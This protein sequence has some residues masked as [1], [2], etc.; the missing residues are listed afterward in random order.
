VT[1]TAKV[2]TQFAAGDFSQ[3][4]RLAT[5]PVASTLRGPT[6]TEEAAALSPWDLAGHPLRVNNELSGDAAGRLN[7]TLTEQ[8]VEAGSLALQSPLSTWTAGKITVRGAFS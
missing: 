7:M 8:I 5:P 2:T 3:G 6:K 1:P 4:V